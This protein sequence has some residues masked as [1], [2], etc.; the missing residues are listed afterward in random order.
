VTFK[1]VPS[2]IDF[3]DSADARAWV[4]R[5]VAARPWRPRF[6]D[7]FAAALN[8]HF[9]RPFSVLE[10]GSGPGHLARHVLERCPVA[11]YAAVD[12]SPAMHD[13]ARAH[14]GPAA[15]RVSFVERDFRTADWTRDLAPVD[16]VITL[17]AAHEIRHKRRLPALLAQIHGLIGGGGL[18]LFCDHYA[19]PG[20]AKNSD[21]YL[22]REEQPE[23]LVQAGFSAPRLLLDHGG[24]ALYHAVPR[25]A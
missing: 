20:T 18:L 22:T 4:E 5:T 10:L 24:M 16:A 8:Q 6:F 7:A 11:R 13:L 25:P 2:P 14:L 15:V 12:F 3:R 1:D 19:E 23:T 9:D 17:Q 21:L